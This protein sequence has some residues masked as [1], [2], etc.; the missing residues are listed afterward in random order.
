MRG[1]IIT[2]IIV[3]LLNYVLVPLAYAADVRAGRRGKR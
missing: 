3:A 1:L 2:G